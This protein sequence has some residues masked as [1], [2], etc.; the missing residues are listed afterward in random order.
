MTLVEFLN[1]RLAEDAQADWHDRA[2]D[3]D[4]YNF[5]EDTG[6][7]GSCDCD[8]PQRIAREVE[9]KRRLIELHER[10]QLDQNFCELEAC[11]E[12]CS[13]WDQEGLKQFYEPWPCD[14]LRLLALPY[15][16]HPDFQAE[17]SA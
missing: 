6:V 7:M 15:A 4:T 14:S 13:N 10:V 8:V 2:S 5:Y 16:D 17:W 11:C 1:A 3:C 9:A 12:L